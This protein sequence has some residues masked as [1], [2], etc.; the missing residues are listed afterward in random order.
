MPDKKPANGSIFTFLSTVAFVVGNTVGGGVLALPM[1]GNQ[2]GF[3]PTV[4]ACL[5]TGIMMSLSGLY[6]LKAF[7][8]N[9]EIL[10]LSGIY[11]HYFGRWGRRLF[12]F[13]FLFLFLC[14]LT[15]YFS[16][17]AE[18]MVTLF[19]FRS[20]GIRLGLFVIFGV[21][22]AKGSSP[23]FL[24]NNILTLGLALTFLFIV[25][26]TFPHI[27]RQNLGTVHWK[28]FPTLLPIFL[29]S[30]GFHNT[31]PVLL[32][33][34]HHYYPMARNAVVT[35][36]V[37]VFFI[38][39]F[40][41]WITLGNLSESTLRDAFLRG[42][43]ATLPLSQKL[44][45]PILFWAGITFTFLAIA[46]SI[47]TV[48][49]SLL[50]FLRTRPIPPHFSLAIVLGIPFLATL[51]GHPLFLRALELG[52]GIGCNI[53]FGILPGYMGLRKGTTLGQRLS[54]LI[55]I[56]LFGLLLWMEGVAKFSRT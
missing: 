18:S 14:L 16:G 12:E 42:L 15:A 21:L 41:L 50:T 3:I 2:G 40:F 22:L 46:T 54:A 29:C 28:S 10:S 55:L 9:E 52:G 13:F 24:G 36:S 31:L 51:S 49:E 19:P 33:L 45:S 8:K 35:G 53:I 5:L 23:L 25:L 30:Y 17:M 37:I 34:T 1:V 20:G 11:E 44:E 39:F 48:G 43:P 4:L 56:L 27:Q 6:L 32:R 38:N 47:L 26:Q 7:W